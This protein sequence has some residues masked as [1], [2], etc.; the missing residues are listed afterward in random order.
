MNYFINTDQKEGNMDN[1][2]NLT[3]T[4]CECSINYESAYHDAMIKIAR[5]IEENFSLKNIIKELSKVI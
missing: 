4:E 5:L 2:E 1:S 3:K